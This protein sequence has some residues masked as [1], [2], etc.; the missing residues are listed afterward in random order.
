MP[1]PENHIDGLPS[2]P[3]RADQA[4]IAKPKAKA[5]KMTSLMPVLSVFD[6]KESQKLINDALNTPKPKE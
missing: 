4:S 1:N 3:K 5:K 2:T 6:Y